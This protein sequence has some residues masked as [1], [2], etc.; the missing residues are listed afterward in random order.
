MKLSVVMPV[1]N[2][3]KTIRAILDRVNKVDIDKE[4]IIIDDF[5]SDGT[6]QVLQDINDSSIKVL[7]HEC[8][9]G[10][11]SALRT[12]FKHVTGDIVI[13]QDAD[14]EYDP[15]EYIKLVGPIAKGEAKVVYGSRFLKYNYSHLREHLFYMTHFLGNK[16]LNWVTSVLYLTR[17]TDM[18]TCYKAISKDVFLRLSL[19]AERFDIEP[20]ITA[21]IL[22]MGIKI[23]EVPISYDPRD[24][25][26]GKKISWRDGV[27]AVIVLLKFK[28]KG[29]R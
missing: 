4:I 28:M 13:I 21:Q 27:A 23:H 10:K 17:I 11:G 1:Y 24:Y 22:N 3:V 14:L 2:E 16:F 25:K 5:S 15:G 6:R 12:G 20:E 19:S 9:R 29:R 8:N 7:M 18:E 26:H